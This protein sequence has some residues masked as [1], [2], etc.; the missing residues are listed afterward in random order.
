MEPQLGR[1]WFRAFWGSLARQ[2]RQGMGEFSDWEYWLDGGEDPYAKDS[3]RNHVESHVEYHLESHLESH[4]ESH[5]DLWWE[6]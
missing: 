4:V 5:V 3:R 1:E 2:R 6:L